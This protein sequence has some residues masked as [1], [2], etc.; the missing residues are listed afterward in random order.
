[1]KAAT[2]VSC[3]AALANGAAVNLA[4]R[5]GPLDVKIE[6]VGNSELKASITN[7]GT[8]PLRVLKAGSILDGAPIEKAQF[9]T[10]SAD[11][12]SR[13][14][15]SGVRVYVHDT[16]LPDSAFQTIAAGEKVEVQWE[17]AQVHDL[18]GGGEY[19]ISSVGS[20]RY[21]EEGSNKIAG[22]VV[23]DSGVLT[24]K[25]D[26]VQAASVHAAFHQSI[27][28]KRATIQ[29]DCTGSKKTAV[30][31]A[32]SKGKAYA[33]AAQSAANA[34]TRLQ[35]YFRST[36]SSTKSSVASVFGKVATVLG[37]TTSGAKLPGTGG[38]MVTCDYFFQ[39][40]AS[41]AACHAADQ[42]YV[43]VHEATHLTEVAGTD[44]VCYG[45]EGC[46]DSISAS[47]SLNNAD[48]FALYANGI[49][50]SC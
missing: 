36:S 45:Y 43:L 12:V 13:V 17:P 1:M 20:L 39:F 27:A 11:G 25:V 44:D 23:Y 9:S 22:Q 8:A 48:S 42:P 4:R 37:S 32:L 49:Q 2:V 31:N 18:S 47:Q 29:N 7:T 40:P 28:A 35:Q 26:G 6:Q 19:N 38:Y 41:G 50:A 16:D 34:G 33:T 14:A 21:A 30:T 46:V 10:A 24:A 5:A 15:F 3:L